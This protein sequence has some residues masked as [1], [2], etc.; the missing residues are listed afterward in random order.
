MTSA[1]AINQAWVRSG[2]GSYYPSREGEGS[3]EVGETP[4]SNITS[5]GSDCPHSF[6]PKEA[7]IYNNTG[8]LHVP[9]HHDL[10]LADLNVRRAPR[11]RDR[12][13]LDDWQAPRH[14]GGMS[15]GV[16]QQEPRHKLR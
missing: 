3:R 16:T 6:P 11:L 8:A 5:A 15:G 10:G 1:G 2:V 4:V 13:W 9:R 14:S 12:A 7:N